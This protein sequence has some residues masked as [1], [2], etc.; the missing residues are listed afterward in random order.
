MLLVAAV[1]ALACNKPAAR[2][3]RPPVTVAVTPVRRA[4]L[5]YTI[6]ANGTVTPLQTAN[7][8]S[9]VDGIVQ[10]VLFQEGQEVAKG[11]VL[12]RIDPRPYEAAVRQ[13][14]AVLTRDHATMDNAV[15]EA[16]RY[17]SLA[18]DK[19]VTQE[20]YE[21]YRTAAASATAVVAADSAAL[22]NARFALDNTTIRAPIAGRTGG[23]L[24]RAGN[25]VRAGAGTPLVVIN[26][27]RPILVRFAVPGSQLPLI[28]HYGGRNTAL[29][30]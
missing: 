30:V 18:R 22:A 2:A 3:G 29:P 7:V 11:Q 28:L 12:F 8:A 14:T 23:L 13:A 26:Q 19:V 1:T 21:A 10:E 15:A 27:V 5:P 6:E 20:Q 24:V 17:E 25:L 16:Q 9:Q 4:S